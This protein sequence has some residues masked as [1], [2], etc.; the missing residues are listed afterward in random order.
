MANKRV[1]AAV[2]KLTCCM[3]AVRVNEHQ[4]CAM[5]GRI[6]VEQGEG[7]RGIRR[8]GQH[9]DAHRMLARDPLGRSSRVAR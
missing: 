2:L 8:P 1:Y 5:F 3:L 9:R 7:R 4:A 6:G